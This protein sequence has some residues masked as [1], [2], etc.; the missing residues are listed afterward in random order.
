MNIIP[1]TTTPKIEASLFKIITGSIN[2]STQY[3][4]VMYFW[5]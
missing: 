5:T 4:K 3:Y 1:A 2:F